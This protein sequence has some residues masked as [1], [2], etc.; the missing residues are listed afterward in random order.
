MKKYLIILITLFVTSVGYAQSLYDTPYLR[1]GVPA[2][3]QQNLETIFYQNVPQHKP[4]QVAMFLGKELRPTQETLDV[5]RQQIKQGNIVRAA[6][7]SFSEETPVL[8]ILSEQENE[9]I[10]LSK[11]AENAELLHALFRELTLYSSFHTALILNADSPDGV[12]MHYGKDGK[13]LL[14]QVLEQLEKQYLYIDVMDLQAC[15]TGNIFNAYQLAKSERIHY[16]LLPSDRRRGSRYQMYYYLLTQLQNDPLQTALAT[17]QETAHLLNSSTDRKTHNLLL[18]DLTQLKQPLK[19]WITQLP[20]DFSIQP[21]K[22][23]LYEVLDTHDTPQA[24]QLKSTLRTSI[25]TQ[26]CYSGATH[27]TY[28]NTITPETDCLDGLSIDRYTLRLFQ[29]ASSM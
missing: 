25:L 6:V 2:N 24:R 3:W 12:I 27:Q 5:I 1:T 20:A 11:T 21:K 14:S 4:W 19:N 13:L 7:L 16:I 8:Y 28:T 26:W 17:S 23:S 22:V 10:K 9:K 18:L 15:F 29:E